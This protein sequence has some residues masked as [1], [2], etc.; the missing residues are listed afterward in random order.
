MILPP[1]NRYRPYHPTARVRRPAPRSAEPSPLHPSNS[2]FLTLV[3][4]R[5]LPAVASVRCPH[6]RLHSH[7]H[8]RR[9]R[10]SPPFPIH[11]SRSMPPLPWRAPSPPP[12]RPHPPSRCLPN[13]TSARDDDARL[14]PPLP[15]TT[16][17]HT[18]LPVPVEAALPARCSPTPTHD[19]NAIPVD[20]VCPL[21]PCPA[22]AAPTPARRRRDACRIQTVVGQFSS[23]TSSVANQKLFPDDLGFWLPCRKTIY[24]MCTQKPGAQSSSTTALS[25]TPRSS[26]TIVTL[27][28]N[29]WFVSKRTG[30]TC[31]SAMSLCYFNS[32]VFLLFVLWIYVQCICIIFWSLGNKLFMFR[33]VHC[34]SFFGQLFIVL[35]YTSGCV[36]LQQPNEKIFFCFQFAHF[37]CHISLDPWNYLIA[38]SC[39]LWT[40]FELY[41]I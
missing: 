32:A 2:P 40:I 8:H 17:Q 31:N 35:S 15:A 18:P 28:R 3:G 13:P 30:H 10:W 27:E 25:P 20:A 14:T 21:P 33:L 16:M 4:F 1:V 41:F 7:P 37:K 22:E 24:N 23:V 38:C 5:H 6:C 34:R 29:D 9:P 39:L 19:D 26:T 12:A 36:N 11:T